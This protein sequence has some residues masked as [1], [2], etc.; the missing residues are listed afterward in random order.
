MRM[1]GFLGSCSPSAR[2]PD[3]RPIVHSRRRIG[4]IALS[5]IAIST[6]SIAMADPALAYNGSGAAAYADK[7][8]LGSNT[9][10]PKFSDDC[11]N[12]VSQALH[13]GGGFNFVGSTSTTDDHQWWIH[14]TKT[15]AWV[16]THS[17]S[18]AHDLHTF[19]IDDVPGGIPEGSFS[20]D[21]GTNKAPAFTPNSVVTGDVLFYDWGTG[22]GISHDSMQVGWGTDA[23]GYYG[24]W[25]DE[26]T[27]DRKH[28]F[29]TLK[30]APGNTNWMTTT[31]YYMH[32]DASNP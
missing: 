14:P 17:W 30:D 19:L 31:V 29:W 27:S 7:W 24:N 25:V 3:D 11:T 2:R 18:V 32:I 26:H 6:A 10:Y 13:A 16:W 8:A 20:Y 5:L 23:Y 9:L 12:F 1:T 28:I 15:G 22:Q 21:N 4:L